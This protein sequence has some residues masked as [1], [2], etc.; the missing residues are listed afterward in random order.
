M[1]GIYIY[2]IKRTPMSSNSRRQH[3][4][5]S[6]PDYRHMSHPDGEV[7]MATSSGMSGVSGTLDMRTS[8][9]G[10]EKETV[11]ATSLPP[12]VSSDTA[13]TSFYGSYYD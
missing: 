10:S 6:A 4:E 12:S 5:P 11:D 13:F 9:L 7:E 2:A 3:A 1:T 8:T